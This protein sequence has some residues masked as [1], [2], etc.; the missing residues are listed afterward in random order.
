MFLLKIILCYIFLFSFTV[1]SIQFNLHLTEWTDNNEVVQHDCLRVDA[2]EDKKDIHEITSYCMSEWPSKWKIKKNSLDQEYTFAELSKLN[3]TSEH[4]Y[5]W[6]APMDTIENYQFYLNQLSISNQTL[7][8][9]YSYVN[10]TLPKFGPLCQYSFDRYIPD[11]SSLNNI[12]EDSFMNKRSKEMNQTCYT[13]L[14]CNLGTTSL[15]IGWIN[16]CDGLIHCIDGI[17]EEPCWQLEIND[18]TENEFRCKNGK[19]IPLNFLHDNIYVPDCLDGSDEPRF[20]T[21]SRWNPTGSLYKFEELSCSNLFPNKYALMSWSAVW[22]TDAYI[23]NIDNL[24]ISDKPNSMSD[25]CWSALTCYL[26]LSMRSPLNCTDICDSETCKQLIKKNCPDMFYMPNT[27]IA[28]GHIYFA[29]TKDYIV[30]QDIW[31]NEPEYVCYNE[32]LCDGFDSKRTLYTFNNTTC[33]RPQDF[34]FTIKNPRV[35]E[36]GLKDYVLS[37]Y[38]YLYKCNT[39]RRNA[40]TFCNSS[41]MYQLEMCGT[42]FFWSRSRSSPG[43]SF[44]EQSQS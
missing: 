16:I 29:Y 4:L 25:S 8:S 7:V 9:P 15:C 14:Q 34:P 36:P 3:I 33:R 24:A 21:G 18:C 12:I 23:L 43:S 41:T 10:C 5:L 1:I 11:Y 30:T 38:V 2:W 35:R 6:S 39:I 31:T 19:C 17:D 26:H 27:P 28:F 40:S 13:H 32:Q 37:V 22:C 44:F 42:R 20:A